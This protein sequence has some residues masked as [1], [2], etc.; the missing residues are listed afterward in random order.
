MD[1]KQTILLGRLMHTGN[2]KSN[3]LVTHSQKY[4]E[5]YDKVQNRRMTKGWKRGNIV[6][7]YLN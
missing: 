4:S 5:L 2:N 7:Q 6:E 1:T 3:I